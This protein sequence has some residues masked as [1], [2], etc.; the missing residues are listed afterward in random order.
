MVVVGQAANGAEAIELI[1]ETKPDVAG[2]DARLGD[3][4]DEPN[5]IEVCRE[6]R[7]EH[8]EMAGVMLTRFADDEALLASIVEHGQARRRW[9][10]A[11]SYPLER[12]GFEPPTGPA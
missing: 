7:S 4:P 6:I 3:G 5:G 11:K 12:S 2:L 9:G 1:P 10:R 8:P